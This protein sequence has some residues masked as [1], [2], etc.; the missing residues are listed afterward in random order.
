M[1]RWDGPTVRREKQCIACAAWKRHIHTPLRVQS[2]TT[3]TH[4]TL[5][6]RMR[7][8]MIIIMRFMLTLIS[9]Q[10]HSGPHTRCHK[11]LVRNP[12]CVHKLIFRPNLIDLKYRD[13][14]KS[15]IYWVLKAFIWAPVWRGWF[16]A[17]KQECV[18]IFFPASLPV[19]S[20]KCSA[21]PGEG[22]SPLPIFSGKPD[23][24][25]IVMTLTLLFKQ[26]HT[27]T[28]RMEQTVQKQDKC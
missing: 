16:R 21:H 20:I 1:S 11:H 26:T 24:H 27:L 17:E 13:N 22:P 8:A 28:W 7:V 10:Q 9:W 18:G 6:Q 25:T 23:T 5:V 3:H 15:V 2:L 12:P 14:D 4:D 19:D